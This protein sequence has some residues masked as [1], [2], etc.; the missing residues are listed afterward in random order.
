MKIY[1]KTGQV[2]ID[3]PDAETIEE[4]HLEGA[5][6]RHANLGGMDLRY[7]SFKGANLMCANL[8]DAIITGTDFRGADLRDTVLEG[9]TELDAATG[10]GEDIKEDEESYRSDGERDDGAVTVNKDEG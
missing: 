2:M 3:Q 10:A 9:W 6:L 4:M 1:S 8:K 7:A 5:D